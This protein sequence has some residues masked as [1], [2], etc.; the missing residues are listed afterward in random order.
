MDNAVIET[1]NQG[2]AMGNAKAKLKP[3]RNKR[4]FNL[5]LEPKGKKKG[6]KPNNRL[7]VI[8]KH[9]GS[10][11]HYDLRFSHKKVLKSWIL[12]KGP[13]L[14]PDR[15]QLAI[16]AEDHPV[17]YAFFEGTIPD[18]QYGAGEVIIWDQGRAKVDGKTK[19]S[20]KEGRIRIHLKG[21]KLRGAFDL[22]R[23]KKKS[24]GDRWV[25]VKK[26]DEHAQRDKRKKSITSAKP[27]SILS[28]ET[29]EEKISTP[30]ISTD[31]TVP[32]ANP[33]EA[34]KPIA[35]ETECVVIGWIPSTNRDAFGSLLLADENEKGE[36][37]YVGRVGIGFTEDDLKTIDNRLKRLQRKTCPLSETP[38]DVPENSCWVRPSQLAT[39]KFRGHTADG[40][41]RY[42]SF[43][44]I[45]YRK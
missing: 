3:Y 8:Q 31:N 2:I 7:F 37:S 39:V 19:K 38:E 1:I 41:I 43:Q 14:D 13:S 30:P 27:A 17:E 24:E 10:T 5:T 6:R 28:G 12:P 4:D 11:L 20:L 9:A 22:V 26:N 23:T 44:S 42:A 32:P 36:L 33:L 35:G 16:Q 29:I 15:K 25:L 40:H 45:R 18:G 21:K 34:E